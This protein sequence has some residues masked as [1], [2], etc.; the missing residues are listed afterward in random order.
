MIAEFIDH[1]DPR[2]KNVLKRTR[3]DFYH[4]PEYVELAAADEGATPMAFYAEEGESACLMPLLIR[5]VPTALNAPPDWFDCASPYGYSGLLMSSSHEQLPSFLEAFCHTARAYGI[6]TAFFRLHPLFAFD[7]SVLG[8]FGT[9]LRH[10]ET[11]CIDLSQPRESIRAQM[12]SNHQRNIKKLTR[13][14]FR[15]SLDEWDRFHDF[16]AVYHSTMRRVEAAE[17]YFFSSAYFEDLRTKLGDRLHLVCVL[18]D[19]NVL[20]AGG[21]FVATDGIV[22]Y[23][24][25]G[26]A[27]EYLSLAP[28]KLMMDCVWR[29]AQEQSNTVFHLGGGVGGA[30]DSLFRFKAG[31]SPGRSQFYTY[32]VVIDEAKNATLNQAAD[33]VR[34]TDQLEHTD[35]FPGYRRLQR[36]T[37]S[38]CI[39]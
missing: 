14:G 12:S 23:H 35:F 33:T 19:T 34:G 31:F 26:T 27:P 28:S 7:P 38:P 1:R 10:G 22:Q 2:W 16:I 24:L 30:D 21:L 4:L 13:L 5:R 39:D 32:R 29:W 20:A 11:V 36:R 18:T 3:H 9:L 15:V 17:P 8:K 6:V 25:G 37:T